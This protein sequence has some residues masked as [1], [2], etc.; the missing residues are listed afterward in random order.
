MSSSLPRD[1]RRRKLIYFGVIACLLVIS[2]FARGVIALPSRALPKSVERMTIQN[3]AEQLELSEMSQG[4]VEL[5]GSAIRLMLTGS[6]GLAISMLWMS[7]SE[8]QMRHEWNELDLTVKSITKLQPH[9]ITPWLFQSWNVAYNVSVEMDRL[10]DMYFYIAKG[11]SLLAEGESINR[12][13]PDMRYTVGFYLQ[14]KFTVHDKVTTMRSLFELSCMPKAE[15]DY[16]SLLKG[17]VIDEEAFLKFCEKN[18]QFVRRLRETAIRIG[19]DSKGEDL[20]L[21]YLVKTRE[22]LVNF[23][24][25]NES[26]PNRFREDDPRTLEPDRLKQ[27][28][29]LPPPWPN[30]AEVELKPTKP[31][32]DGDASAVKVARA[33][34]LYANEVIPPENAEPSEPNLNYVDPERIRKLPRQPTLIIFRQGPQRAQTFIA[35]QLAKDGWLDRDFWVVDR[36]R[37]FSE[38][39]F[40]ADVAIRPTGNSQEEWERAYQMWSERGRANGLK[41]DQTK[42]DEYRRRAEIY[43]RLRGIPVDEGNIP[44]PR[45]DE[46]ADPI[47][48]DSIEANRRLRIYHLNLMNTNYEFFSNQAEA[49]MDEQMVKA[50]KEL[51]LADRERKLRN[52]ACFDMYRAVLGTQ[53]QIGPWGQVLLRFSRYRNARD[54]MATETYEQQMNYLRFYRD[55]NEMTMRRVNLAL[56]DLMRLSSPA[57]QATPLYAGLSDSLLESRIF[58]GLQNVEP[59]WPPGPFDGVDPEGNLWVPEHVKEKVR[60]NLGILKPKAQPMAADPTK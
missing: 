19:K 42:L 34:F 60:M 24:R 47:I 1:S 33:W 30:Q 2:V 48:R 54:T 51:F 53:D 9:F 23:L 46:A 36:F 13:N 10:N 38:R 11:I 20:P 37:D 59:F 6:R 50:R 35:D 39:W 25:D 44:P 56:F 22:E 32:G 21:F 31:I 15:R 4:E 18:P 3:Q 41:L 29:V 14:N 27:F 5:T 26:V 28:P 45:S 43:A 7:A 52:P 49:E 57:I 17:G 40:T 12:N 55:W 8:K 58:P 16:R